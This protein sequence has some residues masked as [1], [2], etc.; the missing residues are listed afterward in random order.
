MAYII[1][2]VPNIGF[3][4]KVAMICETIPNAGIIKI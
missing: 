2:I 3:L 4:E 1:P